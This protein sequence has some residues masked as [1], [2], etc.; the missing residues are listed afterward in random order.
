MTAEELGKQMDKLGHVSDSY[1]PHSISMW[2][3]KVLVSNLC[4]LSF[5]YTHAHRTIMITPLFS[6]YS[7]LYVIKAYQ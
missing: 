3:R 1:L 7:S 6:S 2:S 5:S 4:S